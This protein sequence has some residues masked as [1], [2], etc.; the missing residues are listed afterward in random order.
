MADGEL[1]DEEKRL[2]LRSVGEA[3]DESAA[4]TPRFLLIE[5][6][7]HVTSGSPETTAMPKDN[8]CPESGCGKS[9]LRPE[10]LSRHRLNRTSPGPLHTSHVD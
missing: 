2:G 10:H 6:T 9:F 1:G 5:N 8:R 4:S 7:V 3:G